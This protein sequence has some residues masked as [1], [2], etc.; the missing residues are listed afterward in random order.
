MNNSVLSARNLTVSYPTADGWFKAVGGVNFDLRGTVGLVGESGSGKTSVARALAGLLPPGAR[1]GADQL[2]FGS[3]NLTQ[4]NRRQWRRWRGAGAAS[5]LQDAKGALDPV[6]TVGRQI[7]ETLS[8]HGTLRARDRREASREA[9]RSVGLE[10]DR[11]YRSYP[12]QISGGQA[13]RVMVAAALAASPA[14]LI[15]DEPTSA[16]DAALRDSL[17]ELL[18]DLA[19]RR[20]MGLL[21]V[22]HDLSVVSRHLDEGWVMRRGAFV[23]RGPGARLPQSSHPYTRALWQAR[24]SGRT[25]G[26]PLVVYQE[27]LDG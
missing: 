9:L 22:T 3:E 13:Q 25:Y 5:I 6:M 10:P 21:V 26:S 2:S 27:D 20:N 8:L 1:W 17:L 23:D 19:Q 11:L 24:P 14:L 18:T 15:A 16:L 7:E 4:W 12:H